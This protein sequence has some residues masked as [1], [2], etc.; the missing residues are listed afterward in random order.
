[1]AKGIK[2]TQKEDNIVIDA[3]SKYP[4]NLS[5]A[6]EYASGKL[7]DR[8]TKSVS[9]RYYQYLKKTSNA[10]MATGSSAGVMVNTKNTKRIGR[11]KPSVNLK[12][13]MIITALSQFSKE[14]TVLFFLDNLSDKDK[15][16]I[17]NKIISNI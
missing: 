3:I 2:F 14:K 17:L 1:M 5:Y 12:N 7:I 10:L 4:T 16:T 9:Q 15:I 6:F 11:L 13:K 8:S